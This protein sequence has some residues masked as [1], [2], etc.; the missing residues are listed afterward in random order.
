MGPATPPQ[1][2]TGGGVFFWPLARATSLIRTSFAFRLISYIWIEWRRWERNLKIQTI[3]P[4]ALASLVFGCG[5][6]LSLDEAGLLDAV[7]FVIGGQQEGAIPQGFETR[8]RRT[9]HGR[10]IEYQSIGPNAGF[11]QANDPHPDSRHVQIGVNITSPTKCVFKTVVT[12]E[13]SRGAS[14]ESFGDATSEV[15]TLDFNKVRRFD[16]EGGDS[17][18]VV[19]EGTG[20]ICKHGGCQHIVKSGISVPQQEEARAIESK[21]HA[22]DFI[23]KACPGL[24]R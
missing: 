22:I 13:Y 19:I 21:R 1:L 11:S 2:R 6:R 7:A 24:P 3:L 14:R 8:W 15:T 17:P 18:N 12:S 4:L 16:I 20:W 10:E 9:V 23:K 5:G